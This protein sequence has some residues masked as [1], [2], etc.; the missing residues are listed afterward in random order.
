M[1]KT[2][3]FY[4]TEFLSDEKTID[5]ISIGIVREDGAYYY[6]V[7]A[8]ADWRRVYAD[9]W[10]LSNVVKHLPPPSEWKMRAQIRAEV[11]KFLFSGPNKPELWAW[12][13][14]YDHVALAQLFGTMMQLPKGVPMYTNDLKQEVDRLG[15][16]DMPRYEGATVHDAL[17]DALELKKRY[18][19]VKGLGLL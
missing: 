18:E 9:K 17:S 15:I 6:A 5:L 19:Y 11:T 13:G 3:F 10:L 1:A 16:A 7:S 12:Y 4:D 14:A 8:E 2:K